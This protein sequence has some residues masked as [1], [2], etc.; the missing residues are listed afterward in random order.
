[1]MFV[2]NPEYWRARAEE[3][4]VVA[5]SMNDEHS[6]QMMLGIA[7]DYERMAQRAQERRTAREKSKL[8]EQL[9]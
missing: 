3:A 2:Y 8:A 9:A 1:M 5:E 6:K 7:K 4:H